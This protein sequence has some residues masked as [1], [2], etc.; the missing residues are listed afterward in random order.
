MG[1]ECYGKNQWGKVDE[2][3]EYGGQISG[4]GYRLGLDK[5]GVECMEHKRV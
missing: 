1:H 4:G 2:M 3:S 5:F